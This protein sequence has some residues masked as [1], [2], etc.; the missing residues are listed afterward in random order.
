VP[1]EGELWREKLELLMGLQTYRV[2]KKL[3]YTHFKV[4][5]IAL[6]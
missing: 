6:V 1:G 5:S 3:S 4:Q 2:L